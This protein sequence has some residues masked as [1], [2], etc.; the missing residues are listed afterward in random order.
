MGR[1]CLKSII[2]GNGVTIQ[3]GGKDYLNDKIIKRAINNVNT[4]K[5]PSE[6]Y[7]REIKEWLL[8]LHSRVVDI[9]AGKYDACAYTEEMKQSLKYF[10]IDTK[11]FLKR[12]KYMR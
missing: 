11:M 5:F 1:V 2:I 12:Q 8:L 7:P 3:F 9:V 6:I 10:K 4:K